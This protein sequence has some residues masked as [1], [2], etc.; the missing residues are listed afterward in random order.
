MKTK[1]EVSRFLISKLTAKFLSSK[2]CDTGTLA[3]TDPWE[4][5]EGPGG[6]SHR[7]SRDF[8]QG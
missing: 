7:M 3:N 6:N 1:L 8:Q 4:I 5:P 2:Q